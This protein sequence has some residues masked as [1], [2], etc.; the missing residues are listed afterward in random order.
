ME[1][2]NTSSDQETAIYT[3]LTRRNLMK[4]IGLTT[5]GMGLWTIACNHSGAD[6]APTGEIKRGSKMESAISNSN[7]K[8]G[9][10]DIDAAAPAETLTATFALG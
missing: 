2:T 6:S 9:I 5:F 8:T 3:Y 4:L 1:C 10:P 7:I